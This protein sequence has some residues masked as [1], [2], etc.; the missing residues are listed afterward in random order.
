MRL[1]CAPPVAC[2][3]GQP[4]KRRRPPFYQGRSLTTAIVMYRHHR[5]CRSLTLSTS[6]AAPPQTFLRNFYGTAR[7]WKRCAWSRS[8]LKTP[9]RFNGSS[10]LSSGRLFPSKPCRPLFLGI[11]PKSLAPGAPP[12]PFPSLHVNRAQW[13]PQYLGVPAA[14]ARLRVVVLGARKPRPGAGQRGN[15]EPPEPV[16][17]QRPR[18]FFAQPGHWIRLLPPALVRCRAYLWYA[19]TDH[20]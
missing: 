8:K 14:V 5:W 6:L 17:K 1:R 9:R 15:P 10:L 20:I 4:R 11:D 2:P 7:V 13:H 12:V 19:A 18:R 3:H 16:L